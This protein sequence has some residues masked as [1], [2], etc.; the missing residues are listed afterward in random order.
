M[1]PMENK[2][3]KYVALYLRKSRGDLDSDLDKH[4]M[5][6]TELCEK[7]KW[8]G[9]EY[10]EIK[11]GDSIELR[12]E[13]TRLL[14]DVT[15]GMYDAVCVV[16]IDRLGRGDMGD[17]DRIKKVFARSGTLIIT[18]DHT[19]N[20]E[21]ENDE[22]SIDIKGFIAHQE[23]KLIV[24]RL[25]QGKKVGARRGFWTNGKPPI[26][27]TYPKGGEKKLIVDNDK[28]PTYR[29]II[30]SIIQERKTP[31]EIAIELNKMGV[32]SP[33]GV[34]WRG[35]SVN[36]IAKDQTQLGWIVSNKSKGDPHKNKRANAKDTKPVPEKDWVIV[37]GCHDPVKTEE[38]HEQIKIFFSRLPN[39]ARKS[40]HITLPLTGLIKCGICGSMITPAIRKDRK[41]ALYLR[42][43][44]YV[45]PLGEKCP[46]MGAKADIVFKHLW[47][48]L[49]PYENSLREAM[50]SE[51]TSKARDALMDRIALAKEEAAKKQKVID[52]LL[53]AYENGVYTVDELKSRKGKAEAVL[54]ASIEMVKTLELEMGRFDL[55]EVES[56]LTVV[57]KIKE[58]FEKNSVDMASQNRWL[59][60]AIREIKWTRR[61]MDDIEIE[62][63]FY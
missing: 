22:F 13:M 26:P 47:E 44:W 11:T 55:T 7:N 41:G 60:S 24:K 20:L 16:D 39:V 48:T 57:E 14:E 56:R 43:C 32:P 59:R 21:N 46:N 53:D 3:V 5:V 34:Q 61:S 54:S 35:S 19:Y 12:P 31:Q 28:L 36:R 4:R 42:P 29:F 23:Y 15:T 25:M 52:R 6:L 33:Y 63:S 9:V 37:K 17:Q 2:I 10:N 62:F 8:E 49:I 38:E 58:V 18:P 30:D 51:T 45:N 50:Q 27:Y 1:E 40:P